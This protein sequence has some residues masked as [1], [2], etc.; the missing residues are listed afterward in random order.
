MVTKGRRER[1]WNGDGG[2]NPSLGHVLMPGAVRCGGK[3]NDRVSMVPLALQSLC[4]AGLR[5]PALCS[6]AH[7][8]RRHGRSWRKWELRSPGE[9]PCLMT[10]PTRAA[11]LVRV[12]GGLCNAAMYPCTC[13]FYFCPHYYLSVEGS[14][15][16][17]RGERLE[18]PNSQV[19]RF[20][21]CPFSGCF[22]PQKK[23]SSYL[24]GVHYL[25]DAVRSASGGFEFGVRL[26][27]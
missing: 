19:L 2:R 10:G 8:Q 5:W 27:C 18:F 23:T 13:C 25:V 26:D 6:R 4:C 17:A 11:A 9:Q 14:F 16:L 1:G 21:G 12:A 22:P 15:L 24:L 7:G 3:G 20:F